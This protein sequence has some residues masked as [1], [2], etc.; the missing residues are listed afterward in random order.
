MGDV[1]KETPSETPAETPS[2]PE[3]KPEVKPEEKKPDVPYDRFSEVV[4]EK[5]KQR[6]R[7][8]GFEKEL[9]EKKDKPEKDDKKED[10]SETVEKVIEKREVEKTAK[11]E[12]EERTFKKGVD[13]ILELHP[14]IKRNDFLKFVEEN[15]EKYGIESVKGAFQVSQDLGKVKSTEKK[16]KAGLPTSE[17]DAI[18]KIAPPEGDE[19]KSFEQVKEAAIEEGGL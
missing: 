7:A 13:D 19:K 14:D 5:N 12:S 18:V 17:G 16:D 1:N 2:V 8:D 10:I 11:A 3:E 6:D 15:G 9:E 4:G